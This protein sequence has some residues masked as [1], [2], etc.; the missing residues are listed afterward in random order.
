MPPATPKQNAVE[1]R[2][3]VIE[4][5]WNGFAEQPESRLLR[6][7]ADADEARMVEVFLE[8]QNDEGGLVPDLFIR[9]DE[10]FED[11]ARYGS[12]LVGSLRQK[13]EEIREP[14]RQEG[15]NADWRC[16]AAQ[17]G[18][19]EIRW[20]LRCC[21]SLQKHYE[22][23]MS[24]L[25]VVLTPPRVKDR[26]QWRAWLQQILRAGLPPAV[27]A[28]VFD[29]LKAPAL[30]ELA[31]AEPVL[32][33]TIQP[34][35]DMPAAYLE[36]ARGS[37]KPGPGVAF[38]LNFVALTQAAAQ[39]NLAKAKELGKIALGIAQGQGWPQMQAV[40]HMTLGAA[41]LGAKQPAEAITSY[42]AVGA[43]MA[44]QSKDPAAPKLVLQSKLAEGSALVS[45]GQHP[46]AAQV[47][48]QAAALAEKQQDHLLCMES[49]RMAA[50]CH[51]VGTQA[52]A[53]WRCGNLALEAATRMDPETRATS[54]LPFVGQGL[55][56]LVGKRNQNLA[57]QVRER[58]KGLA[59]TDWEKKLEAATQSV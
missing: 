43:L 20:F 23:I 8:V 16:P 5:L 58:M 12:I 18:E 3:E 56:R 17:P 52:E 35:L 51:E 47:Y 29:D 48:E 7:L 42:R 11:P 53:S 25:V 40:I 6:W 50:Y 31:A 15:V 34:N 21:Q 49:W 55:L 33:K 44:A 41:L 59:G 4:N 27:R 39:G 54:T 26:S 45:S 13:Y 19:P 57:S 30:Q 46:Q 22:S 37:G 1:R 14:I 32:V 10:P 2:L 28:M 36:L 9:F 24:L 38:R